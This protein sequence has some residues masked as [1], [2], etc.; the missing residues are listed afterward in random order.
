M[1]SSLSRTSLSTIRAK[2]SA[3]I[4][5]RGASSFLEL[6]LRLLFREEGVLWALES[7]CRG[8][9]GLA[10]LDQLFHDMLLE[11]N[12]IG[13]VLSN[14]KRMNSLEDSGCISFRR[15]ARSHHCCAVLSV[16]S[17]PIGHMLLSVLIDQRS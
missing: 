13:V 17:T 6:D 4:R 14:L 7:R 11:R 10:S 5:S 3:G 8:R 2:S 16:W 9:A 12:C 1:M 15:G